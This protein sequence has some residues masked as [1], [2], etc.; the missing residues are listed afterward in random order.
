MAGVVRAGRSVGLVG[1]FAGRGVLHS[2]RGGMVS[3]LCRH[4][5]PGAR[6]LP[7]R[8]RLARLEVQAP[9]AGRLM[10]SRRSITLAMPRKAKRGTARTLTPRTCR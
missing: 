10:R 8:W 2:Q 9:S 5:V 4:Q 1:M 3:R 6:A 7:M